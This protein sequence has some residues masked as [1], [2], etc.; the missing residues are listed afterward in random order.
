MAVN[1][2]F[3]ET[4]C[5]HALDDLAEIVLKKRG[6]LIAVPIE[7]TPTNSGVVVIYRF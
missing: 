4:L 5:P 2:K 3:I 1:I 7:C 6:E